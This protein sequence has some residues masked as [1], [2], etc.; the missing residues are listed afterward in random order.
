MAAIAKRYLTS[1]GR[2]RSLATSSALIL[3]S[4]LQE[5]VSKDPSGGSGTSWNILR[6]AAA[7]LLRMRAEKIAALEAVGAK[8]ARLPTDIAQLVKDSLG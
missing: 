7:R 1:S 5:R 3:R 6:D 4:A 8:V 2:R